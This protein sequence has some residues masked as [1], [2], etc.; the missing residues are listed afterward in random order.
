MT[1]G[2]PAD[3]FDTKQGFFKRLFGGRKPVQAE[4]VPMGSAPPE[5]TD[6]P[7]VSTDQSQ[8]TEEITV[9]GSSVEEVLEQLRARGVTEVD[10][11]MLRSSIGDKHPSVIKVVVD[12]TRKTVVHRPS[13][14]E[15]P[16]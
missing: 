1:A 3:P 8:T 11:S 2:G 7:A 5:P 6:S 9:E 13:Q 15:T 16:D 4:P 12:R 14:G 10:E